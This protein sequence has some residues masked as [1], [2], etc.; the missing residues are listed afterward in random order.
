M[1]D[2]LLDQF[3]AFLTSL[4]IGLLIGLERE[5]NPAARAGLRTFAVVALF[6]TL[7]AMLSVKS[8]SPWLLAVGLLSV[9]ASIV[10]SYAGRQIPEDDPGTTTEAALLVCY[11][12]G[13]TVWFGYSELAV[14]LGI[15]TTLLLYFKP[16]LRGI[17]Q[18]MQRS[19]LLS[20]LQF[21]VLSFVILP[22]LPNRG[23]GPYD[24]LNP[25]HIWL[26]VVLISGVSLFGYVA[27]RLF[28]QRYGAPFLGLL[29]GL[30]SSTATTLVYSH[31]GR[32]NVDFRR[33][34]V[35][36]ILL[37]NL[38]LLVRLAILGA[39]VA[40]AV[41]PRLLPVLGSGL[42][43]GTLVSAIW[44]RQL[45]GRG[46]FPL[47]ATKNPTEIVTALSFGLGYAVV[48][49]L[50]AWLLDYFGA[51]G[52]YAVAIVSGMTD[53]DT[54]TLSS[55]HMFSQGQL[56]EREVML[57]IS[58]AVMA[59]MVFKLSLV[60]FVSGMEMA[61]RCAAGLLASAAGIG[62]ALLVW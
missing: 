11:T 34:A 14:I 48:L 50:S 61:K 10:V 26:M 13:A 29:G 37:A 15:L 39:V 1:T 35:I 44:W 4:A 9:G 32:E 18:R 36:V 57:A 20:I 7:T 62:L 2:N 46:D 12:L 33:L 24:A 21:A 55:F 27:L 42:L 30:V 47:P 53:V 41:L 49:V 31:Y 28:G 38:V 22:M 25:Y 58:F 43:A 6:G 60:F 45:G 52:L 19:D 3:P 54:I 56:H 51:Q 5:R 59:N 16:E 40:P 8:G 23:F 17:S